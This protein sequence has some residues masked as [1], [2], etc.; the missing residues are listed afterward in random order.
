[1]RARS[2]AGVVRAALGCH[3]A[4]GDEYIRTGGLSVSA[5]G[6]LVAVRSADSGAIF[7]G[8]N[9]GASRDGDRAAAAVDGACAVST[10]DAGASTVALCNH[11]SALDGDNAGARGTRS[12]ISIPSAA[13]AAAD[14]GTV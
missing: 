9:D 12:V 5:C 4:A 6:I 14:T 8:G 1:M 10:T 11:C 7:A 13:I 2:D 3:V